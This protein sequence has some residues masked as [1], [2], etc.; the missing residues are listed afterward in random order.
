MQ[1]SEAKSAKALAS[2]IFENYKIKY[3]NGLTSV[4]D[5]VKKEAEDSLSQAALIGATAAYLN[6]KA[7][8]KYALGQGV[9]E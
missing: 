1:L 2:N 3:K 4:S 7:E 9:K 8:Y 5:L 6:A